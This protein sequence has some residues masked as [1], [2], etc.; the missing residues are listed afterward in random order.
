MSRRNINKVTNPSASVVIYNYRDRLGTSEVDANEQETDQIILNTVSLMRVSTSK[1]KMQPAGT[2]QFELAPTKNWTTA[3]T[4]GSWCVI[5]MGRTPI[6]S[7]EVKY[8][9]TKVDERHFKML[10]RIE[11]VRMISE[12][13]QETGAIATKYVVQGKDWGEIF[14]SY[15]YVDP[16][17]RKGTDTSIGTSMRLLYDNIVKDYGKGEADKNGVAKFNSTNAVRAIMAFWGINDSASDAVADVLNDKVVSKALN[18]FGFPRELSDYMGFKT[19]DGSKPATLITQ[20]LR[21]R[22][23]VLTGYDSYSGTDETG[24]FVEDIKFND[25]VG[26]IEPSSIFGM[27]TVWQLLMDNCNRPVNEVLCDVRFDNGKPNLTVY[28]RIKP[29]AIR[30][31]D[32]I[33]KDEVEVGEEFK[34]SSELTNSWTKLVS[35][36]AS[37]FSNVRRVKIPKE[38]V[39]A[40]AAGT[41]WRDKFNMIEI[42]F[43]RQ[44][45]KNQGNAN[46]IDAK[47]KARTQFFDRASIRRDGLRP[48][49]MTFK[50][51]APDQND[52]TKTNFDN[53][54]AWKYLGKEWYFDTHKMLN[55]AMSLIGQDQYIQVGDNIIFPASVMGDSN[56][57]NVDSAAFRD[58]SYIT[59]HVESVSHSATVGG[60]GARNFTTEIQFVRGI[61]TDSE[62][63]PLNIKG[64][65]SQTLDQDTSRLTPADEVNRERVFGTST[66]IDPD[67]Q[68]LRGT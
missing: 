7:T 65:A 59:A 43:G 36:F 56:N 15:L 38:D 6:K 35:K 57:T 9:N 23:G 4:P 61:V 14:N 50:Y 40:A 49:S 45:V 30:S 1:N 13:N 62:G 48:L 63:K 10:G 66:D 24:A 18:T 26:F 28:K 51:I 54:I 21:L 37:K 20:V 8:K 41:N 60:T 46:A 58:K 11:S 31:T 29:F 68:R 5:L 42:R 52:P 67:P 27:N 44:T 64:G 12:T 3:I 2:F 53:A 33:M 19:L 16:M 39:I 47:L 32:E 25:G 55:G 17:A 22:T 34:Q